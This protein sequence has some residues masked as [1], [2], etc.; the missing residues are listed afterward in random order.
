MSCLQKKYD[1]L[2][3]NRF[4]GRTG[5][6]EQGEKTPNSF[7]MNSPLKMNQLLNY[8]KR[9]KH[10]KK[11]SRWDTPSSLASRLRRWEQ[12]QQNF[13]KK[14]E[15]Q[16]KESFFL[17]K[18]KKNTKKVITVGEEWARL[19]KSNYDIR[20]PC[21]T[22]DNLGSGVRQKKPD[23]GYIRDVCSFID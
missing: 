5:H 15:N 1:S 21:V 22:S 14:S 18:K 9:R 12:I 3:G 10:S 2:I 13:E 17:K 8:Q 20:R 11:P 16:S 23:P 4:T 19:W 7:K 6:R